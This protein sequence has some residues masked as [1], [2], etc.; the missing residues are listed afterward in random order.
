M[1]LSINIANVIES[2]RIAR[3]S[4]SVDGV[5]RL[6][7]IDTAK[8]STKNGSTMMHSARLRFI[9]GDEKSY[10]LNEFP[11]RPFK[12]S[13]WDDLVQDIKQLTSREKVIVHCSSGYDGCFVYADTSGN[14]KLWLLLSGLAL[15]LFVGLSYASKRKYAMKR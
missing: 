6:L 1:L 12:S 10:S 2:I 8:G 5:V 14:T 9:A 15:P 7:G 13:N 11:N 4:R 3:Q